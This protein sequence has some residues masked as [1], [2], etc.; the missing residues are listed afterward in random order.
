[1]DIRRIVLYMALALVSLSLWNAWQV[2]YPPPQTIASPA[3]TQ[4]N[5]GQL[6]PRIPSTGA[7][8]ESVPVSPATVSSNSAQLVQVKT[9]VLQVAIDLNQ[10]NVVNSDLLAYPLSVDEKNKPFALLQNQPQ[11]RYVA[12]SSLFIAKG[13]TAEAVDFDFKTAEKSYQLDSDQNQLIVTLQGKN[14]DGLQVKKE[15]T[16]TRGSYL[17]AVNYKIINSSANDWTGYLNTQFRLF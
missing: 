12:N 3:G 7:N 11:E 10:G 1:M 14:A 13:Q 5:S 8:T 17:I 6:L 16:F 2:D 9:D 4:V 15:F